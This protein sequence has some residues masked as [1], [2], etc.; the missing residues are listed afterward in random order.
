ML[1][2]ITWLHNLSEQQRCQ[3]NIIVH[4][5]EE[6]SYE[7]PQVRKQVGVKKVLF[8]FNKQLA[9]KCSVMNAV[10]RQQ[11]VSL[12]YLILHQLLPKKRNLFQLCKEDN[13]L[14]L[15]LVT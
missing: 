12:G 4:D 1:V 11:G 7:S 2:F 13:P 14:R 10:R 5:V 15:S 6:S 9:V 3:L 8:I